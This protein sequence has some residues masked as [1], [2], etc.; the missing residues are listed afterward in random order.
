MGKQNWLVNGVEEKRQYV[1]ILLYYLYNNNNVSCCNLMISW[2]KGLTFILF[3]YFILHLFK[4]EMA[5]R[6]QKQ[7]K[8][9]SEA[10]RN[11]V[12]P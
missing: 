9:E 7:K 3:I 12:K 2:V 10:E 8:T 1:H 6:M 4:V 5:E 11:L